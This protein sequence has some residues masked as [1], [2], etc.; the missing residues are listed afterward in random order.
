[1][2][3]QPG[4]LSEIPTPLARRMAALGL[5]IAAVARSEPTVFGDLRSRCANCRSLERCARDL[6]RDP[7]GPMP[8]CPNARL[9]NFLTDMW[10]L[11]TLL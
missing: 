1:M 3:A 2:P 7:A 9:L 10:W 4:A 5:D 8:Y 6:Q 11:R